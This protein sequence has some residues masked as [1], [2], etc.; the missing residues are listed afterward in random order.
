M[1]PGL[2]PKG[3]FPNPLAHRE[4][5][6]PEEQLDQDLGCSSVMFR[7][8]KAALGLFQIFFFSHG[9]KKQGFPGPGIW[10]EELSPPRD[11]LLSNSQPHSQKNFPFLVVHLGKNPI[12][13]FQTFPKLGVKLAE[14]PLG[15][16]IPSCSRD[17]GGC[18]GFPGNVTDPTIDQP[19][20]QE[21]GMKS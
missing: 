16:A 15:H 6:F 21:S 1:I 14:I 17:S 4:L 10:D 12:L 20:A 18:L 3:E 5:S 7:I 11:F 2:A 13:I 19:P 8:D 9:K